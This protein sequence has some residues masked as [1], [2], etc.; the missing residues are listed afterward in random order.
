MTLIILE[1]KISNPSNDVK[2]LLKKS[3][4]PHFV[5]MTS[6]RG[7][8]LKH[9]KTKLMQPWFQAQFIN[10]HFKNHQESQEGFIDFSCT[11]GLRLNTFSPPRVFYSREKF[12]LTFL[13]LHIRFVPRHKDTHSS[14][15]IE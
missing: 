11:P 5:H 2:N 7:F 10:S 1:A 12:V 13:F 6:M 8:A 9:K 3:K 15:T 14:Y 4:T